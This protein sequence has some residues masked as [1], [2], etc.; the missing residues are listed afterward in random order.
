MHT[1][2][3]LSCLHSHRRFF[4]PHGHEGQ[5]KD[6]F[7]MQLFQGFLSRV[8]A[9]GASH[10]LWPRLLPLKKAGAG[11]SASAESG[12]DESLPLVLQHHCRPRRGSG[13]RL[14]WLAD[15]WP[16][17][18]PFKRC[19][20]ALSRFSPPPAQLRRQAPLQTPLQTRSPRRQVL[21]NFHGGP[22][23][24][25]APSFSASSTRTL[26]PHPSQRRKELA[27]IS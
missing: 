16:V 21:G 23:R 26:A 27:L 20:C 8:S 18:S 14:G 22:D 11:F 15:I 19:S 24:Y 6:L 9:R 3:S 25:P 12:G 10:G 17:A 5:S 1:H 13:E 4:G 7:L 2:L